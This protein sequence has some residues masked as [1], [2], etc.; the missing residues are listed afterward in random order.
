MSATV[1]APSLVLMTATVRASAGPDTLSRA[2]G[3]GIY[4]LDGLQGHAD[5]GNTLGDF[6]RFDGSTFAVPAT[7][8][9]TRSRR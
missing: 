4:L 6:T 5:A 3:L 1:N 2:H 8:P 9:R 7:I